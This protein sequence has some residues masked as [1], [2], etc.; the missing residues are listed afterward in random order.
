M[1]VIPVML[2][3]KKISS[4]KREREWRMEKILPLRVRKK[5]SERLENERYHV[6]RERERRLREKVSQEGKEQVEDE[7]VMKIVK[8]YDSEIR[9][10]TELERM[11][12]QE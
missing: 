9:G 8:V 1:V 11:L 6:R 10:T 3:M 7:R 4:M 5:G 2:L 12:R